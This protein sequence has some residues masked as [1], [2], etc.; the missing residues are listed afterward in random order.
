MYRLFC[1]FNNKDPPFFFLLAASNRGKLMSNS[2]D[3]HHHRIGVTM[4]GSDAGLTCTSNLSVCTDCAH[5]LVLTHS[6]FQ[7]RKCLSIDSFENVNN[8]CD[9]YAK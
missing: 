8:A 1:F 9:Y 3:R 4:H 5:F 7:F 2:F 6:G